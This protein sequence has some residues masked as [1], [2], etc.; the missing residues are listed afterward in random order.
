MYNNNN[1]NNNNQC[2]K[3]PVKT[4]LRG[5]NKEFVKINLLLRKKAVLHT[6]SLMHC[7]G[8]HVLWN[9]LSTNEGNGSEITFVA[10]T[11]KS[12]SEN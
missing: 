7:K 9:L 10:G 8:R 2:Q 11:T 3:F 1:D 6:T 12:T 5:F 4:F